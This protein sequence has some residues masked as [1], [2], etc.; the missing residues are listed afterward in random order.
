MG[1]T[2]VVIVAFNKADVSREL[3]I[4]IGDEMIV[5]SLNPNSFNTILVKK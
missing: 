5:S 1:R 3:S 4:K 2:I